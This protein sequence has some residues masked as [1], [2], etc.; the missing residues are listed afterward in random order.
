MKIIL[1]DITTNKE[2][3]VGDTL[4]DFRGEKGVLTDAS[5]YSGQNGHVYVD[6]RQYYPSVFKCKFIEVSLNSL[7]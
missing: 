7:S 6:G 3:K 4:T 1:I 2:V 5:P